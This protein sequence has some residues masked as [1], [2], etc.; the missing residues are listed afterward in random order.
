[1]P[2]TS[3]C[4]KPIASA[5]SRGKNSS[6]VFV[7]CRQKTSGFSSSTTRLTRSMRSRTELMFQVTMLRAIYKVRLERG[8]E[9]LHDHRRDVVIVLLEHQHMAITADIAIF[10]TDECRLHPGLFEEAHGQMIV[11]RVVGRL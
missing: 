1:M 4:L 10:E 11:G 5:A 8:G 3:M 6:G 2:C 7:S 9:P